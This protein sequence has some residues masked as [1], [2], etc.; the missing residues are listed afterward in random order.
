MNTKN[1]IREF[2]LNEVLSDSTIAIDDDQML[3]TDGILDSF[4]IV[5]LVSEI[6]DAFD[7]E[8]PVSEIIPEN[9]ENIDALYKTIEKVKENS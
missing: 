8:F 4:D 5:T 3:L 2:I 6:N 7:I 9:F 1:K